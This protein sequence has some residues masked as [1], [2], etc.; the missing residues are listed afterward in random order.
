[1]VA[2]IRVIFIRVAFIRVVFYQGGLSLGSTFIRVF[3]H[4]GGFDQRGLSLGWLSSGWSFN[5]VAFIRVHF[6]LGCSFV[7][8]AF[9]WGGLFFLFFGDSHCDLFI[10]Q[11]DLP[12]ESVSISH[13]CRIHAQVVLPDEIVDGSNSLALGGQAAPP[14][15]GSASA[16]EQHRPQLVTVHGPLHNCGHGLEPLAACTRDGAKEQKPRE[17]QL[18]SLVSRSDRG[19]RAEL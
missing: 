15:P 14:L 3:F 19:F 9:I 6:P 16:L 18:Q 13:H 10:H 8:V 5:S 12:I 7:R 2:F 11:P 17:R 1:M 4:Y